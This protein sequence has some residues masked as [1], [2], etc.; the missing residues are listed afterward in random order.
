MSDKE[1]R[2]SRES[3]QQRAERAPEAASALQPNSWMPGMDEGSGGES[4]PYLSAAAGE[5]F[6]TSLFA[7]GAV[8]DWLS[9]GV[10]G[11]DESQQGGDGVVSEAS[12]SGQGWFDWAGLVG[13]SQESTSRS[14]EHFSAEGEA[15]K[16]GRPDAVVSEAS[17]DKADYSVLAG[18][19]SASRA[20]SSTVRG[21]DGSGE[22][23][24]SSVGVSAALGD[25]VTVGTSFEAERVVTGS[26]GSKRGEAVDAQ[27]SAGVVLDGDEVGLTGSASLYASDANADHA[28]GGSASARLTNKEVTGSVQMGRQTDEDAGGTSAHA[29]LSGGFRSDVVGEG[30]G[31]RY[32]ETASMGVGGEASNATGESAFGWISERASD[33]WEGAGASV[34]VGVSGGADAEITHSL[35][36]DDND[37]ELI[38]Q[39]GE[40]AFR[41]VAAA[42]TDRRGAA[43]VLGSSGAAAGLEDG[44]AWSLQ[45]TLEAEAQATAGVEGAGLSVGAGKTYK[46]TFTVQ[47]LTEDGQELVELSIGFEE[48]DTSTWGAAMKAMG[49]ETR[50]SRSEGEGEG[51]SLTHRISPSDPDFDKVYGWFEAADAVGDIAVLSRHV[52]GRKGWSESLGR[53]E[54]FGCG[55]VEVGKQAELAMAVHQNED[56]DLEVEGSA[57]NEVGLGAFGVVGGAEDT[58]GSLRT[59]GMGLEMQ[60]ADSDSQRVALPIWDALNNLRSL[61]LTDVVQ[62]G[63]AEALADAVSEVETELAATVQYD[64]GDV[65]EMT[66]RAHMARLWSWCAAGYPSDLSAWE[67]LRTSL[68]APSPNPEWVEVDE[69]Q[70]MLAARGRALLGFI[71]ASANAT[72]ILEKA[73]T[74]WGVEPDSDFDTG[75]GAGATALG[76]NVDFA[77]FPEDRRAGIAA[78]FSK[79]TLEAPGVLDALAQ[80]DAGNQLEPEDAVLLDAFVADVAEVQVALGYVDGS[81]PVAEADMLA[82][83]GEWQI[84]AQVVEAGG[85]GVS[86]QQQ[87]ALLDQQL[88]DM[89]HVLGQAIAAFDGVD[90]ARDGQYGF[91]G[92]D[93]LPAYATL[94]EVERRWWTSQRTAVSFYKQAQVPEEQWKVSASE[95]TE[96][97]HDPDHERIHEI[98]SWFR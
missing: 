24:E 45:T 19:A 77:M 78:L 67:G 62:K 32:T 50:F 30:A 66:V 7:D 74:E 25:G 94:L 55:P 96:R 12:E 47:K 11:S 54:E 72:L 33:L 35:A 10:A 84:I 79:V 80:R 49:I 71:Y 85:A 17:T 90:P 97:E 56:G 75:L 51:E 28:V 23:R 87:C 38:D 36:L 70:A 48:V 57:S 91:L 44:E 3:G 59:Q 5:V 8:G 95:V 13:S 63:P 53:S 37:R 68:L 73:R 92:T 4:Y 46:R 61:S 82:R 40:D 14:T 9:M 52:D 15:G 21:I 18:T 69:E 64:T 20:E 42:R 34:G 93:W 58:S 22:T 98:V 88:F 81:N 83:L 6:G 29:A 31:Q 39:I 65:V 1:F 26:D 86:V 76:A 2:Q 60:S 41:A 27:T 16:E 89:S 43:S